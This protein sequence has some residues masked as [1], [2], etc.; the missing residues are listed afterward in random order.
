M[1]KVD[2]NVDVTKK[3]LENLLL[4]IENIKTIITEIQN[5]YNSLDETVWLSIEKK[6]LDEY[7]IP[8]I[9]E[10]KKYHLSQLD[11]YNKS[12]SIYAEGYQNLINKISRSVNNG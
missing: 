9:E 11:N 12:L 4:N 1:G 8:Y 3:E 10:K 6:K 5:L 7:L 2:F